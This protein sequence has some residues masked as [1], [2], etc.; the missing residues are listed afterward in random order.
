MVLIQA[1]QQTNVTDVTFRMMD[2]VYI[3]MG[4]IT[5]LSAIFAARNSITKIEDR[6][7][8]EVEKAKVKFGYDAERHKAVD[9]RVLKI[10]ASLDTIENDL[11]E[12]IESMGQ[13]ISDVKESISSMKSEILERLLDKKA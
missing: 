1:I 6:I 3:V 8:T 9:G 12:K 13:K 10:E 11:G 5:I 2:V 4:T 7:N